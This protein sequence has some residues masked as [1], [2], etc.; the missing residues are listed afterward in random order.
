[1][2]TVIDSCLRDH[3]NVVSFIPHYRMYI[4]HYI[5]YIPHYIMY[6]PHYRMYIPHYIMYIPHTA[7]S[8]NVLKLSILSG[9]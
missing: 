9:I 6:I 8:L 7:E 2:I 5:M 4:P 3:N 1:M